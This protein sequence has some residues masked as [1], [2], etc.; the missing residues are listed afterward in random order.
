MARRYLDANVSPFLSIL[1]NK[2]TSKFKYDAFDTR[3]RART[4]L[5]VSSCRCLPGALASL[6][7]RG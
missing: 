5:T 2:G 4:R 1:V 7:R 3:E 6:M